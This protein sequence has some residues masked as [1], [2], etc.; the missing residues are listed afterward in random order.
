MEKR[1]EPLV[2]RI[3]IEYLGGGCFWFQLVQPECAVPL[4]K[5]RLGVRKR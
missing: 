5:L 2:T 3:L 4:A 1:L